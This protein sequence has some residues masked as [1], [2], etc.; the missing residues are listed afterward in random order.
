KKTKRATPRLICFSDI[1]SSGNN[2]I[3]EGFYYRRIMKHSQSLEEAFADGVAKKKP[4]IGER[5][6]ILVENGQL[7]GEKLIDRRLFSGE[8]ID[9][10]IGFHLEQVDPG[11]PETEQDCF[12]E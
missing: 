7:F 8:E 3:F 4:L 2:A 1:D 6:R 11:A 5:E 12:I 10:M 9:A